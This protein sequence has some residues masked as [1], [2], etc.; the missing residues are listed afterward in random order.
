MIL[1]K[2][3]IYIIFL[4]SN[5]FVFG[6]IKYQDDNGVGYDFDAHG[7]PLFRIGDYEF[8]SNPMN[9]RAKGYSIQGKVKNGVLNFPYLYLIFLTEFSSE[10]TILKNIS[11]KLE[12]D[13]IVL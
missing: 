13:N 6:S 12:N 2:N 5:I 1:F 4:L 10:N 7:R 8:P 9:D 11:N 3:Y